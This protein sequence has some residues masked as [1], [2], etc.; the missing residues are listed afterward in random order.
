MGILR[1][2]ETNKQSASGWVQA[3]SGVESSEGESHSKPPLHYPAS[4]GENIF[5][6][7]DKTEPLIFWCD[8]TSTTG[9]LAELVVNWATVTP[10]QAKITFN[11]RS[12]LDYFFFSLFSFHQWFER[13]HKRGG[14]GRYQVRRGWSSPVP[15]H[16]TRVHLPAHIGSFVWV[17][18]LFPQ[19]VASRSP[20]PPNLFH[21][22]STLSS[23][24]PLPRR[25]VHWVLLL[26]CWIYLQ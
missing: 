12:D 6:L 25:H 21:V 8:T 1:I 3:G 24:S 14:R 15:I 22:C 18:C 4:P 2:V 13:R 19:R 7:Y 23:V 16:C 9:S 20:G 26:Q 11:E 5:S 10:E 17:S